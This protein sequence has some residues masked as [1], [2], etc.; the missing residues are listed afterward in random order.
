MKSQGL[1]VGLRIGFWLVVIATVIS[2]FWLFWLERVLSGIGVFFGGALLAL[3]LAVLSGLFTSGRTE[4]DIERFVRLIRGF[5]I[6][7]VITAVVGLLLRPVHSGFLSDLLA[8]WIG[9]Q[10]IIASAVILIV[11][12]IKLRRQ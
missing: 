12:R 9:P 7:G 1:R 2:G 4:F 11:L 6:V 3:V 5:L 8:F 10:L